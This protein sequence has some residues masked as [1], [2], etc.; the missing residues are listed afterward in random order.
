[1][2]S[3][4]HVITDLGDSALLLPA[5][6]LLFVYLWAA[7]HRRAPLAWATTL[8][9]CIGLTL[10]L[11]F[12]FRACAAEVPWLNVRSPSGHTAFSATLYGCGFLLLAAGRR[13][14]FRIALGLG[15]MAIVLAIACSRVL[16]KAHTGAEVFV[17]LLIGG[18]CV[19]LFGVQCF[20]PVPPIG[21]CWRSTLATLAAFAVLMHGRH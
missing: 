16:L 15:V 14:G 7:G 4:L 17:G 12:G 2:G 6:V 5:S 21:L 13:F 8:M 11:K 10:A 3:L 9:L 1:M 20:P 19:A 18:T